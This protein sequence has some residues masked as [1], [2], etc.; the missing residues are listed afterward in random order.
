[1][2]RTEYWVID[3]KVKDCVFVLVNRFRKKINFE[4]ETTIHAHLSVNRSLN[5]S[6][7]ATHNSNVCGTFSR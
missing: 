2:E 3:Y 4:Y 5:D 7:F 1:M 6:V